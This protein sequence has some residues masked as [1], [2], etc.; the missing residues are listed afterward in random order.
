M[1]LPLGPKADLQHLLEKL[2]PEATA[3]RGRLLGI[4]A[5]I[6]E[7]EATLERHNDQRRQAGYARAEALSPQRRREI[8]TQAGKR[9]KFALPS[10]TLPLDEA[11]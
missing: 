3:A 9:L 6:E 11:S 10:T 8:A 5:Y 2:P 4:L 7:L 1:S